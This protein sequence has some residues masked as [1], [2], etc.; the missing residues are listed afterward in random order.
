[1]IVYVLFTSTMTSFPF[2]ALSSRAWERVPVKALPSASASKV[3]S[4]SSAFVG[5]YGSDGVQVVR[6]ISKAVVAILAL[7]LHERQ[8]LD[9]DAPVRE[10]WPEF[11]ANGK[12]TVTTRAI[13]THQAGL[14]A[15]DQP[16]ELY[17]L[18]AW[19]P[20]VRALESQSLA[21]EPGTAVGYH[22]LTLG[23]LVGEVLHRVT[24]RT[25]GDL[26]TEILAVPSALI[27]GSGSPVRFCSEGLVR[28]PRRAR[29]GLAG[30]AAGGPRGVRRL[31]TAATGGP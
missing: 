13:L 29:S 19:T 22:D 15:I 4:P 23:W 10:V 7:V 6:S 31:A 30:G 14:P 11:G 17:E 12:G 25:P 2:W 3:A 26:V 18:L 24:G 5:D 8:L 9:L 20:P 21:W 27:C 16:L 28:L 1:M